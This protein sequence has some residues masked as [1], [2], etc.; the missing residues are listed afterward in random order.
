MTCCSDMEVEWDERAGTDGAGQPYY[1][2]N[3]R[4]CGKRVR[5]TWTERTY[6]VVEDNNQNTKEEPPYPE[7]VDDPVRCEQCGSDHVVNGECSECGNNVS[8]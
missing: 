8:G 1:E 6:T 3:C 5:E 4:N 2:G 7:H